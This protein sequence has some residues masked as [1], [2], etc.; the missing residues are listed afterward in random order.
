MER[1]RIEGQEDGSS[2]KAKARR[3]TLLG[4]VWKSV[5][6]GAMES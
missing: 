4:C 1:K 3:A 6:W 5:G 2:G